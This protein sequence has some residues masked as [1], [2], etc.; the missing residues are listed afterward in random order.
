MTT[1]SLPK[2]LQ[3][4]LDPNVR[5]L[6]DSRIPARASWL[7]PGP[8]PRVVP[9]WFHWTGTELILATF[10]GSQKLRELANGDV[11]AVT[12][13]TDSFP[14]R[15]L[16]L[17]GTVTLEPGDGLAAAYRS[18]AVRYLGTDT[19]TRWCESLSGADQVAICITPTW[20]SASDMSSA[21]FMQPDT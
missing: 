2:V 3:E 8:T 14:Y 5:L 11:M 18:A 19:G 4:P 6:L 9:I 7:G 20:A 16:K 10:A 17:R 1:S 13:D 12:I 15:A 21:S